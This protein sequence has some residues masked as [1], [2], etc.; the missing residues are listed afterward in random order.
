MTE[1]L[2]RVER[3]VQ[4]RRDAATEYKQAVRA[5]HAAG[6]STAAIARA[7]GVSRQAVMKTLRER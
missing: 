5:A 1:E 3:A 6:I 7:A 4:A 2:Q